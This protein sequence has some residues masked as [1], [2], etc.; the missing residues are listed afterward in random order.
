MQRRRSFLSGWFL[1]FALLT[2]QTL[3]LMH[4]VLH[5]PHVQHQ[6]DSRLEHLFSG[7]GDDSVC[8]LFDQAS[9]GDGAPSLSALALPAV[10]PVWVTW[11]FTRH[12]P[13]RLVAYFQAR[14]PPV[15]R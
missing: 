12:V 15:S 1:A 10:L 7:H 9:H 8:R 5:I 14:G 3:G 13:A 11:V 6:T 4:S 2:A